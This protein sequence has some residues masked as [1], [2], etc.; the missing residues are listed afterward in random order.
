VTGELHELFVAMKKY[1]DENNVALQ[2]EKA[3]AGKAEARVTE[4]ETEK[5]SYW[6]D[7]CEMK[8]ISVQNR[9]K[10]AEK[11]VAEL[12]GALEIALHEL[13]TS[14]NILATDR[15]DVINLDTIIGKGIR[16]RDLMWMTDNS[17]AMDIVK[18]AL[19][20]AKD[21]ESNA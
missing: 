5:K 9:S 17:K 20:K 2:A 21:G 4:L 8:Y 10:A 14:H 3:R 18:Q 15:P 13:T 1:I 6:H 16:L 11:H 12:V 7:Y 19:A